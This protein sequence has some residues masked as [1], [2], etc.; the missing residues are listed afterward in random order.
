VLGRRLTETEFSQAYGLLFQE[1]GCVHECLLRVRNLD[2]RSLKQ[3]YRRRAQETHP[4]RAHLREIP[5]SDSEGEFRSVVAAYELLKLVQQGAVDV[6]V[7]TRSRNN[8]VRRPS[9]ASTSSGHAEAWQ[10]GRASS[11]TRKEAS[12]G[13][14]RADRDTDTRHSKTDRSGVWG[15]FWQQSAEAAQF[16]PNSDH[17]FEKQIPNRQLLFGQ[18][19][20][21]SGAISWRQLIDALVW[22]RQ[23]RPMIGQLAKEWGLLTDEQVRTVLQVRRD[24]GR[25]EIKFADFA[26]ELGFLTAQDKIALCGRLKVMQKPLG[27]YFLETGLFTEQALN[28]LL[29]GHR[30]HNWRA[31]QRRSVSA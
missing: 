13:N 6:H 26:Q 19:L 7:V 11:W 22:Q 23:Q 4:D 3:A 18:Y 10:Q 5:S 28:Q 15:K 8:P 20:Y 31:S 14:T 29:L 2:Q 21:Y 9:Q 27:Q 24:S 25:Y 16:N 12:P 1:H 30:R 17:Y